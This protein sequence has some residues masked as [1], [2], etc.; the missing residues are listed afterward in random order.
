MKLKKVSVVAG[1][2]V[3]L[4]GIN[5]KGT[6]GMEDTGDNPK[7]A[8]SSSVEETAS[9]A[10]QA[11]VSEPAPVLAVTGDNT[12]GSNASQT[13]QQGDTAK[14]ADTSQP[15]ADKALAGVTNKTDAATGDTSKPEDASKPGNE[16]KPGDVNQPG[17][18]VNVTN[19][20]S[21][22]KPG[23][24]SNPG[25]NVKPGDTSNPGSDVKPG[26]TSK[27]GTDVK[28]G[29]TDK[30]G[31]GVKPGDAS[32]PGSD[33]KPGDASKP[34]SDIKPGDSSKPGT[35]VKPGDTDKP[36]T[37]VKPGDADKPGTDVK[38]G[39]ADKPGTDIKPGDA[40]K[41]GTDVKPGDTDKLVGLKPGV[42]PEF[43]FYP[44]GTLKPGGIETP[45]DQAKPDSDENTG[46]GVIGNAALANNS[47]EETTHND[48]STVINDN[49]ADAIYTGNIYKPSE[50]FLDN[51][52]KVKYNVSL[53]IDGIPSFITQEMIIGALKCQDETGFP[54]SVTIAQIIQESGFGS[55]GP[56]GDKGMG[57]SYLAFQYNN[58]FG[59]KGT[60]PA[61]SVNMRTG[62]QTSA[63]EN[64][65]TTAGFR[66]YNTY[67]ECIED[68]TRLLKEV[69]SD[70]TN[71]VTDA[72]TFAMN[73]GGRWATDIVYA[74][75][76]IS[77]MER[78][79]L[80]R[81]DRMTLGEFSKMIGTFANPCPGAVVSSNFGMR[82]FRNSF[83]KGIDLAT[84]NYNIP[85]YAAEAGTVTV[86]GTSDTAGNW[87]V[88]DHGN[89]LVTKYMHNDKI[90][91]TAGQHVEKGQQIALSGSTGDSTGNH[92]HFQVEENGVAV[93]PAPYLGL[94]KNM[95]E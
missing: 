30:P 68:R 37:G 31:T 95:D 74:Q 86:A 69:Y 70:L 87:V 2:V 80:Y 57:L 11:P 22:A 17:S 81:L 75:S 38:P 19:P 9:E 73:I 10:P 15:A 60:G 34:G 13:G 23:D 67:T 47:A 12:N 3:C 83:H 58:L 46:N 62:E 29:D 79:D 63:G 92:L 64:Y 41:P 51:R 1:V 33:V 76:L 59:I 26:D 25:S 32:K 77:Q 85:V 6:F 54:A 56:D 93:D 39:D 24:A 28:P 61:G 21:D 84:G 5:V 4:I 52:N 14:P 40:D 72:N 78:Y 42:I 91:V 20:G 43:N 55:Y 94:K 71:G 8:A 35:D 50:A 49:S 45:E 65:M 27:P 90:Y 66:I 82:E 53:P 36:G 18:D 88:I 16:G 89:G 44:G 48:S 7:P